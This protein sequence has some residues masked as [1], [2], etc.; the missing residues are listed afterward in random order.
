M[1]DFDPDGCLMGEMHEQ[2]DVQLLETREERRKPPAKRDLPA[3]SNTR[4]FLECGGK[5]RRRA[6]AALWRAAEAEAPRRFTSWI[7]APPNFLSSSF[8]FHHR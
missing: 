5:R 2:S 7:A 1:S 8:C 3:H 6:E 4:R